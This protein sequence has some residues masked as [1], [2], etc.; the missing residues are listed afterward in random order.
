MSKLGTFPAEGQLCFRFFYRYTGMHLHDRGMYPR[1]Q[2]HLH[3]R[4]S[5]LCAKYARG[6]GGQSRTQTRWVANGS[7]LFVCDFHR[8]KSFMFFQMSSSQSLDDDDNCITQ[9]RL[10]CIFLV[11]IKT[12]DSLL[13]LSGIIRGCI[14]DRT[15]L[16]CENRKPRVYNGPWPV[17]HC[18]KEKWCNKDIIPT[19]PTP[20]LEEMESKCPLSWR[21]CHFYFKQA[22]LPGCSETCHLRAWDITKRERV[23][24]PKIA[25]LF[26]C[27]QRIRSR[28]LLMVWE[29][30][31]TCTHR[32]DCP[33]QLRVTRPKTTR[34]RIKTRRK[35]WKNQ[36]RRGS[37][38]PDNSHAEK[39]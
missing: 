38:D 24:V 6:G 15:P 32:T 12:H 36:T 8:L 33:T 4:A 7:G 14:D 26:S 23:T 11:Q 20:W 35:S 30:T 10:R 29:T 31:V 28:I 19:V 34:K 5:V 27:L 25:N 2:V 1:R 17:L 21:I 18:C 13:V 9:Q 39:P 37:T 3:I 22:L 16:L